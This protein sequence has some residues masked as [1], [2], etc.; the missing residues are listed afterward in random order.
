MPVEVIM[1]K[2]DMDMETGRVA[3]W[4]VDEGAHVEKGAPLFD[5]ETDK[6][7]MEVESPGAGVLRHVSVTA[8]QS[9][10]IGAVIG[11][12]YAEGEAEAPPPETPGPASARPSAPPPTSAPTSAPEPTPAIAPPPAPSTRALS[13]PAPLR[14]R[15][16]PA[17]RRAAR[18]AGLDLEA[19]AG[20]GPQGRIQQADV[21][22]RAEERAPIEDHGAAWSAEAGPLFVLESGAGAATP[23]FLIHGFAGDG[24]A[25]TFIE[26]GLP[27]DRRVLRL[28]LP[29]HGRS[30][31][32]RI[33]SFAT[34]ARAVAEAF[35]AAA[36][37]RAHIVGHSLGGALALALADVRPR[38]VA[39]LSLIAPA[40]LGP[41]IRDAAVHGLARAS[42]AE[43]LG[44]WLRALVADPDLI[45]DGF[46]RAA[47]AARRDPALRAAQQDMA[48]ALFPDG[49]Q[50]FD[51][52]AALGRLAAPTA[53][54]WGRA[55]PILPWRHA[56]Q[57]PGRIA[58]HLLGAVGHAPHLEAPE[59]TSEILA[60]HMAGAEAM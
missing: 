57:A 14:P 20:S 48:A 51:L 34:L 28:E 22:A 1:P 27:A 6:A 30:P 33:R 47:M 5:I 39:S 50:A 8:G 7:A 9:A 13:T 35:D 43:S 4:H 16:T 52:R 32:R 44:P 58:L 54:L 60:R 15:A 19:I 56:L 3:A 38:A 10:P 21:L 11:W 53:I 12:I 37:E 2:V 25:F 45:D 36:L 46:V 42:R 23:L 40:G 18:D 59:E 31:K 24:Y 26:P 55:D 49:A 29:S 41:D 17:A